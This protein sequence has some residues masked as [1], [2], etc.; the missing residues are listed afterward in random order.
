MT[1]YDK[2]ILEPTTLTGHEDHQISIC[3]D[4]LLFKKEAQ[5]DL[6]CCDEESP[7]D[8]GRIE[9]CG[10]LLCNSKPIW[11]DNVTLASMS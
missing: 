11:P 6:M 4:E 2:Y 9:L 5:F 10:E 3:V 8:E 7:H 1:L